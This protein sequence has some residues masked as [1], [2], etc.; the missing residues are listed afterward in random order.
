MFGMASFVNVLCV[1]FRLVLICLCSQFFNPFTF[2]VSTHLLSLFQPTYSLCSF[3]TILFVS[4]RLN[5]V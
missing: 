4:L 5:K 3:V 2:F 1:L